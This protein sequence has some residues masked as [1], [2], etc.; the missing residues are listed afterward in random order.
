MKRL[1]I[2]IDSIR[3]QLGTPEHNVDVVI[4]FNGD[5][6][7]VDMIGD[8]QSFSCHMFCDQGNPCAVADA[9]FHSAGALPHAVA[10]YV[11]AKGKDE[12]HN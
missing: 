6:V 7:R 4:G 12:N 8:E 11:K 3:L 1:L 2:D 5:G 9:R 10:F